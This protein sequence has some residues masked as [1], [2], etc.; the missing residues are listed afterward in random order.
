MVMQLW[1][2][3]VYLA[4]RNAINLLCQPLVIEGTPAQ[5]VAHQVLLSG[6]HR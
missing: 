5:H 4:E 6:P 2:A 3:E 1:Y